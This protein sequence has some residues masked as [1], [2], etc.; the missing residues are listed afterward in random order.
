MELNPEYDFIMYLPKYWARLKDLQSRTD[1]PMKG[2][3]K[4]VFDLEKRFE[5]EIKAAK[6][7][8]Q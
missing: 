1:R 3:G 7:A 2:T 4:S 6:E 5:M 8:A